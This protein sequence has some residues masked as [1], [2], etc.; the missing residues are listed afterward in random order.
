MG[1]GHSPLS[2]RFCLCWRHQGSWAGESR[3]EPLVSGSEVSSSC[4]DRTPP[5]SAGP[6]LLDK[7][8]SFPLG[9]RDFLHMPSCSSIWLGCF[10]PGLTQLPSGPSPTSNPFGYV[11]QLSL[12][13]VSNF[14]SLAFTNKAPLL[15]NPFPSTR[16]G[17]LWPR[18]DRRYLV[19]YKSS[20]L[21]SNF[22]GG[23]L[24]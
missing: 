18:K 4:V 1:Q 6:V 21:P 11:S 22:T 2:F 10:Y 5:N 9:P 24:D 14:I 19:C 15:K 8:V 3:I 20:C 23:L 16:L 12:G 13:A 17:P 7:S